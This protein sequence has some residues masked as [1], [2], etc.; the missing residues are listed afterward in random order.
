MKPP[1]GPTA[2]GADAFVH[3]PALRD[4]L[5]APERSE[6]RVTPEV[7]SAWDRRAQQLGRPPN[8]R[9]TDQ[10]LADGRAR[11]LG[12]LA[13]GRELWV[14]GY[15]SLMWDPGFHFAEVRLADLDGYRRRF[16]Y[17]SSVGRGTPERPALMLSLEP[18]PG[19]CSGLV[20]RI[21]AELA[22]AESQILWRREMLRNGYTPALLPAA[23][24]QGEVT[25]L[26]FAANPAHPDHVGELALDDAA[27]VIACASGV[28]G[29]NRDYLER[30]E[31]QLQSLGIEDAYVEQLLA[32]VRAAGGP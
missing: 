21:A 8:W 15:G 32:R 9:L 14:F 22:D 4:R 1:S 16:S 18:G 27:A 19:R 17:R 10:Q 25:A 23:T 20:F 3:V 13:G 7:L 29:S 12:D 6:L 30:L 11:L 5:I 31:Q 28:I 24:P 2:S 26:V